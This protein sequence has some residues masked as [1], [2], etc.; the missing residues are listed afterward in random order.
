MQKF[1]IMLRVFYLILLSAVLI[2]CSGGQNAPASAVVESDEDLEYI[3]MYF[4]EVHGMQTKE[5]DQTVLVFISGNCGSCTEKTIRFMNKMGTDAAF[6]RY[7]KI[8]VLPANNAE[9]AD[10][11]N[12]ETMKI[13]IEDNNQLGKYGVHFG[14][15]LFVEYRNGEVIFKDQLYLDNVDSIAKKYHVDISL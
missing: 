11:L 6:D 1:N 10:S 3:G 9:V 15:N 7:E 13:I 4:D 8:V 12:R 5:F 2:S 14:K